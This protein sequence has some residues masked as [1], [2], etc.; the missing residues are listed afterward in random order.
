MFVLRTGLQGNGK[1]LNT[2]KEVDLKASQEQRTVYYH[3]IRGFNPDSEVLQALWV[4]FSDPLKWFE[5]PQNAIIVID[6]AQSFF[7]VRKT[8]DPV[9]DYA[10]ALE[11]MRHKGHELHCITQNPSLIDIHFRK[12]CNSHIHYVRG[13]KG[14]II[15][16]W[17]FEM[18]N[19]EVERKVNFEFGEHS[20]IYL[21]KN[22]FAVYE[23]TAE[24]ALHHF[25][26]NPPKAL[27][28]LIITL[29]VIGF[30][31][32][33]VYSSRFKSTSPNLPVNPITSK[34]TN[35]TNFI[36]DLKSLNPAHQISSVLNA[37]KIQPQKVL[38]KEEYLSREIPRIE[39]LP[40]SA[41]IYDSIRQV[42]SYP[43]LNCMSTKNFDSIKLKIGSLWKIAQ[44]NGITYACICYSQQGNFMDVPFSTCMNVLDRNVPFDYAKETPTSKP[45]PKDK[46][47]KT[48]AKSAYK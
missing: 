21:D 39:G 25:K 15:K 41:P 32:F 14:K 10:S 35:K 27:Y 26:F 13:H 19:L 7:R 24:G 1:T 18:V 43:V 48:Q 40:Y 46:L 5:L 45:K 4:Q 8:S 28:I 11:T 17:A 20:R 30:L 29:V 33:K 23:S 12:L 47:T 36:D 37:P 2:I 34:Q 6:E 3:N 42:R 16:R 31:G 22:Y 44:R 38:S 9:P